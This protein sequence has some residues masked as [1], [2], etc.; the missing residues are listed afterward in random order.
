V[1]TILVL[2]FDRVD[3]VHN[4]E[5]VQTRLLASKP[6]CGVLVKH[7]NTIDA[8]DGRVETLSPIKLTG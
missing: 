3:Y 5:V 8:S 7:L 6:E 4:D 1:H 2:P